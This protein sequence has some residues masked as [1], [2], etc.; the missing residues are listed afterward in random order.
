M[1]KTRIFRVENGRM[2]FKCYQC[3]YKRMLTVGGAIRT[4]SIRCSKCGESTRCVFNRRLAQRESQT[5]KAVLFTNDG[6][7]LAIDLF[8]I[9]LRGVGFE[10]SIRDMNK[11]TVGRDVQLKCPWNAQLF[12]Q[13]RY[14]VRSVKGQRVGVEMH[15]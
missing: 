13:G 3:D 4:K 7:E 8:D 11:I 10:L 1:S 14:I 15:N 2:L 12:S 9:S 5:G 6:K